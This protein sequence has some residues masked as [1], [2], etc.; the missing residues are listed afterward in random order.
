MDYEAVRQVPRGRH[1]SYFKTFADQEVGCPQWRC[2]RQGP[3]R[4]SPACNSVQSVSLQR[5]CSFAAPDKDSLPRG[6][7]YVVSRYVENPLLVGGRKFD[8][9]IYVLVTSYS[10]LRAYL[11]RQGFARFC[12]AKYS[13][14]P[15][16]L[17][18]VLMHLTNVSV[19]KHSED[20]NEDHGGKWHIR[21]L[22]L[23]LQATYGQER[24]NRC[25]NLIRMLIYHTLRATQSIIINDK[26]CFELYGYDVLL[27]SNLKPWL[28]EVNASPSLS[29]TTGSDLTLKTGVINDV[30]NL[31]FPEDFP[32]TNKNNNRNE[33]CWRT[34]DFVPV[35][36][37]LSATGSGV[38]WHMRFPEC[39]WP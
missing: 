14:S 15:A 32:E 30:L 13:S 23:Y 8:L 16:D 20:Y 17:E 2:H 5:R 19:Q 36:D 39:S 25:F 33:S 27:D 3:G 26:H 7:Q 31:V 35:A 4:V 29:A 9:R 6:V 24:T 28:I 11:H 38:P 34:G 18:N 22:R 21:N 1:L 12:T 37:E 10:P